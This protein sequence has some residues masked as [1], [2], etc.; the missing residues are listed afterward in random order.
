MKKLKNKLIAVA[1]VLLALAVL[2][3]AGYLV[4]LAAAMPGNVLAFNCTPA[5][6][7]RL[8]DPIEVD[9]LLTLPL[10][11]SPAKVE[12]TA[13]ENTVLAGSPEI[14]FDAY[15][16]NKARYRVH[17]R[18]RSLVPGDTRG[19]ITTVHFDG[20]SRKV[21]PQSA[22]L[23]V[24]KIK[25]VA[26]GEGMPELAGKL[27]VPPDRA[28]WPYWAAGIALAVFLAVYF[29]RRRAAVEGAKAAAPPW[30][31]TKEELA[32]L[33][34]NVRTRR[35]GLEGAF[36]RL[37]DLVRGYLE[38]RYAI[39]ASTRTTDEFM[40]SLRRSDAPI[41]D[42]EKPFIG[43]FLTVADQV[44]FARL[45]PDEAQLFAA[46]DGAETLVDHTAPK[47]ELA[48]EGPKHV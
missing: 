20:G 6:E 2:A 33:K 9:G 36:V 18:L 37:T 10:W 22:A 16:W 32:R 12:V 45:A 11:V 23:P 48:E 31:R 44:K 28:Y 47:A 5:T 8:G 34:D 3:G 30:V 27:E 17:Y 25:P 14:K 21:A 7:S 13:P 15:R 24:F 42:G 39:P 26:G 43:E 1:A 46:V 19:G 38:E 4:S 41:P 29:F 35:I 40:D